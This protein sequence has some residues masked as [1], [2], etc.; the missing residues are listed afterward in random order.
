MKRI[1]LLV[2]ALALLA[3]PALS[4]GNRLLEADGGQYLRALIACGDQLVLAGD[5]SLFTWREGEAGFTAW[6]PDLRLENPYRQDE[7]AGLY[8]LALFD[9]AGTLRGLRL[10][11][12]GDYA[13]RAMQL[14]DLA[15][16][17]AGAV[18]AQNP[19]ELALPGE[20]E[21]MD[22]F[23]LR[24]VVCR[25]GVLYALGEGED[26]LLCVIDP[27]RPN[28][29]AVTPL[30]S[31]D[32]A[33]TVGPDGVLLATGTNDGDGRLSLCRVGADGSLEAI[34][35]LEAEA[36][37]VAAD[38]ETGA[39]YAAMNGQACPVDLS[40]GELGEPFAALTLGGECAAVL[41]GGRW[42][43]VAMAGGVAVLD[44]RGHLDGD[45]VL[46]IST[47]QGDEWLNRAVM[48]FAVEHPEVT[49]VLGYDAGDPLEGMMTQSGDTDV[50]IMGLG[51]DGSYQAL[52][53][54]GFMLPL[55]GSAAIRA[56]VE[57]VYPGIRPCISR[58]GA[59]VALPVSV[60]GDCM[61][62]SA[63]LLE[64]LGLSM[65]DVPDSWPDFLDFM[66][67]QLLPR[68][69]QLGERDSFAYDDMTAGGFRYF[70][71]QSILRDW[72][73]ANR[74]AGRVADWEDPRLV[75]TLEKLDGM[76]FAAYGLR[77]DGDEDGYGYGWS[78]DTRYLIQVNNG[79]TP[80]G[81]AGTDGVPVALGFGDDLPGVYALNLACAFVNPYSA[82]VDTAVAFLEALADALPA[83]VE[84][85]LCPDLNEPLKRDDWQKV[86]A[87]FQ[88]AVALWEAK[89]EA[90]G[91]AE[92]QELAESLERMKQDYDRNLERMIW[93]IPRDRLE[94]YRA[95]GDRLTVALPTWFDS[96]GEAWELMEQYRS[97]LLSAREF[98]GEVNRKARMMELEQ[99]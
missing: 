40:T 45:S 44:T 42:Y 11:R 10:L 90:A 25:E 93:L 86:E 1:I 62:I 70:L 96:D 33:L 4:E 39:V 3:L 29:A 47:T 68:L 75:D 37:T 17:D 56:L 8:D 83:Q 94:R 49:P 38:P 77:E 7:A 66:E 22:W 95:I 82:R 21:A 27:G 14:F 57:R 5:D 97:R 98:L 69:D 46:H 26:V 6:T 87:E 88:Q 63:E 81:E 65:A 48:R 73:Q 13:F 78:D 51:Y 71:F 58:D 60:W 36:S 67:A 89:L 41:P 99:G 16:T 30:R 20:I 91:P 64:K 43:A 54:R 19:V 18:T 28:A 85:A 12:D 23:D 15:F 92:K 35:R 61:A 34:C 32:N 76:D 50:Y 31:W 55:D 72:A 24:K 59:P 74:A 9:D 2:L 80:D 52:L 79:F 53:E 84:Y